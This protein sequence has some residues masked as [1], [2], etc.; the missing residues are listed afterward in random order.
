MGTGFMS[1]PI[2]VLV[3]QDEVL[4]RIDIA[5]YLTD[6]GF[7]V[8][9]AADADRAIE[10]MEA[11][12]SIRLHFTDVDMPGSM[13]GLK[14]SAAV[15]HRWPPVHII[16]TSGHQFVDRSELPDGNV[17]FPKPYKAPDVAKSI[18]DLFADE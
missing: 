15:R 4:V 2:A 5:D 9:E 3:V 11:V 14:L 16:V 7:E 6:Q 18:H 8:Y 12:P 1:M 17:F 10:I 13:N